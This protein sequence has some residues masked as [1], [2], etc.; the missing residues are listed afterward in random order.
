[1]P[2]PLA[3]K[4]A[5]RRAAYRTMD[6][7]AAAAAAPAVPWECGG[8]APP[9]RLTTRDFFTALT[10]AYPSTET[11]L[12]KL[13]ARLTQAGEL[14]VGDLKQMRVPDMRALLTELD[15]GDGYLRILGRHLADEGA[16]PHVFAEPKP[17]KEALQKQ[18]AQKGGAKGAVSMAQRSI[19]PS[20]A[21]APSAAL[22]AAAL[23]L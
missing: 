16:P 5:H 20:A 4:C 6:I 21:V 22:A 8:K 7:L 18:P 2:P 23:R 1:M 3:F 10:K 9:D 13:C 15:I 17:P 19:I 12:E 14:T 11:Y